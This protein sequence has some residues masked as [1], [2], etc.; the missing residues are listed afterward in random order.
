MPFKISLKA[1][2][3]LV[4]LLHWS[5]VEKGRKMEGELDGVREKIW[6]A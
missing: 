4:E 3:K 1:D 2:R 5:R 6:K